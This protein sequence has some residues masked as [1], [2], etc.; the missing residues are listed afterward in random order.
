ME[1]ESVDVALP[2]GD[3]VALGEE[4]DDGLH[5]LRGGKLLE[6]GAVGAGEVC[7]DAADDALQA[8]GAVAVADLV[9]EGVARSS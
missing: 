2:V 5:A 3:D 4:V 7:G 6:G 8:C 1:Q 9:D